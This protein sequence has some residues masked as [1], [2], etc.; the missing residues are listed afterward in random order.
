[1]LYGFAFFMLG[2]VVTVEI[3]PLPAVWQTGLGCGLGFAGF[4]AL[5]GWVRRNRV[6][7]DLEDWCACAAERITVRVIPSRRPVPVPLDAPEL[8]EVADEAQSS[9][10]WSTTYATVK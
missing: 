9:V 7:L 4:A 8:E 1:M 2:A 5:A 3:A 10:P 6:A